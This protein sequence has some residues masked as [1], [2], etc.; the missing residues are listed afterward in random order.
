MY[1]KQ[2][3]KN[4]L[5]YFL[6]PA[7]KLLNHSPFSIG[8]YSCNALLVTLPKSCFYS[9]WHWKVTGNYQRFAPPFFVNELSMMLALHGLRTPNEAFFHRNSKILAWADNLGRYILG[10]LGYFRLIYQPP[11]WYC[12]C[13]VHVFQ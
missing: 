10:H 12:E 7:L 8:T 2:V 9:T 6:H 13:L 11:F 3:H 4:K 1:I 5:R